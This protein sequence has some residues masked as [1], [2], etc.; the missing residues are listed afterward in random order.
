M[1]LPLRVLVRSAFRAGGFGFLAAAHLPFFMGLH[2]HL[3]TPTAGI[4]Q[5]GFFVMF[6]SLQYFLVAPAGYLE[7]KGNF[8]S[9]PASFQAEHDMKDAPCIF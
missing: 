5:H 3:V 2:V 8:Y 6:S 9:S 1:S 7:F 4:Q